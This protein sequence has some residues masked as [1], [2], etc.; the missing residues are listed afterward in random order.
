[1]EERLSQLDQERVPYSTIQR[2]LCAEFM[3]GKTIGVEEM[4]C[5]RQELVLEG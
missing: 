2:T 1:M 5:K 3:Q 4:Y